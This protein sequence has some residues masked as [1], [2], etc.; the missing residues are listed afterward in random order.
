MKARIWVALEQKYGVSR[1]EKAT[2]A[3]IRGS[4]LQSLKKLAVF[5]AIGSTATVEA[6]RVIS[7]SPTHGL[8]TPHRPTVEID[9]ASCACRGYA[10]PMTRWVSTGLMSKIYPQVPNFVE[11]AVT[12]TDPAFKGDTVGGGATKPAKLETGVMIQVPFHIGQGDVVK[13]DT[14]IE[15]YLERTK[16]S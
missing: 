12:E 8:C 9:P 5:A 14:R 11:L 13:V 16:K 10:L 1:T 15:K 4:G 3:Q 7:S 6:K 2:W